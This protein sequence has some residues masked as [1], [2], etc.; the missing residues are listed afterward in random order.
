MLTVEPPW[1]LPPRI[2]HKAPPAEPLGGVWVLRA[3][4]SVRPTGSRVSIQV[5]GSKDPNAGQLRPLWSSRPLLVPRPAT[6]TE[7][8][9]KLSEALWELSMAFQGIGVRFEQR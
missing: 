6:Y 7:A 5:D 9:P 4:I 2:W 3:A 8:I 1:D